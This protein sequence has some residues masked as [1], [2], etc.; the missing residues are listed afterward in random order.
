MHNKPHKRLPYA[1]CVTWVVLV[2]V[3]AMVGAMVVVAVVMAKQTAQTRCTHVRTVSH[4][5]DV[6][7]SAPGYPRFLPP[8]PFRFPDESS[9][10]ICCTPLL[11]VTTLL[12]TGNPSTSLWKSRVRLFGIDTKPPSRPSINIHENVCTHCEACGFVCLCVCACVKYALGLCKSQLPVPVCR[13][14]QSNVVRNE[15]T[16]E[17]SL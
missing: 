8:L 10:Q 5:C 4:K 12:G 17:Q 7:L 2:M 15:A 14:V 1:C 3:G 13:P 11:D 9:V 16:L 6:R